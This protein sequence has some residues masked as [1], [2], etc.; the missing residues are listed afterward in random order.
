MPSPEECQSSEHVALTYTFSALPR[1]HLTH[2]QTHAHVCICAR[3][4][5]NAH[6]YAHI[7]TQAEDTA[8][9]WKR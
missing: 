7:H 2:K 3:V 4:H 8:R 1:V 9:Y 6:A 5:L